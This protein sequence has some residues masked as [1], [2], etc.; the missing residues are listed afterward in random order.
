[1]PASAEK[2]TVLIVDD[3][4]TNLALLVEVLKSDYRT[5]VAINGE[6]ALELASSANPPDLILL[7]VMMP[8]L[9]GYEVC[10]RL[11]AGSATS[12]I[13]VIFITAMGEVEDETRGLDLGGVDYVTKPIRPAI[14]KAR[15]RTHLSVSR[16]ARELERL[17]ARLER[18]AAE[19]AQFNHT[20]EQ[21]VA[22][23]IGQL[24]RLAG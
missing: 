1:M 13:P 18:Q 22:E 11:K 16:Q 20:L 8:G 24:E 6:K 5:T 23:G 14:V 3:T 21:R 19:L 4:P 10:E 2:A 7:D 15:I 12:H 9:N 17:V